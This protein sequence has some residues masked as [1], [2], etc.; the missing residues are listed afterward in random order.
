MFKKLIFSVIILGTAIVWFLPN[1]EEIVS[2]TTDEDCSGE[3]FCS[4]EEL[5]EEYEEGKDWEILKSTDGDEQWLVSAIHGGGIEEVT[6]SLTEAVAG[7][8]Y[9]FY[10]FKGRLTSNNFSNLH[11]TSTRFDE[12]QALEMVSNTNHHIAIHGASGEEAKTMIGGMDK[13]LKEAVRKH[14][15]EKGFKVTEAPDHLNGD[16]PDNYTNQTKKGQG[17]QIEITRGQR[18]EFYKNGDISFSSRNDP[19]NETKTFKVYVEALQ[20]AMKDY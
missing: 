14:L 11:I 17:V 20:A 1:G 5:N 8:S 3:R 15:E 4:F 19:S 2:E 7:S 10:T 16:H 9:P 13:E 12:P 6:S 18:K